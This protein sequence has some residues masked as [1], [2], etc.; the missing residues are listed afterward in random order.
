MSYGTTELERIKGRKIEVEDVGKSTFV[1]DTPHARSNHFI[2]QSRPYFPNAKL[3]TYFDTQCCNF[4]TFAK[5][6]CFASLF[7]ALAATGWSVI[8][9]VFFFIGCL[10]LFV[11]YCQHERVNQK[12]LP[13][14][15]TQPVIASQ[16]SLNSF[17]EVTVTDLDGIALQ[18]YQAGVGFITVSQGK[19]KLQVFNTKAIEY[20]MSARCQSR[21]MMILFLA[22]SV[23]NCCF[24]VAYAKY[25][26]NAH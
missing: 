4:L 20:M 2:E 14:V 21:L 16:N 22:G 25:G 9:P 11:V 15:M 5:L 24:V 10:A 1:R 17:Y 26:L 7:G 18:N 19:V 23:Y 13:T 12:S 8:I 6:F 3:P